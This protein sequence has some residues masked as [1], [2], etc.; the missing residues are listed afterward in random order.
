[1]EPNTDHHDGLRRKIKLEGLS[2]IYEIVPVG[3]EDLGSKWIQEGGADTIITVR[4]ILRFEQWS[5]SGVEIIQ[6]PEI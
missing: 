4:V 2:D 3:A 6:P 1:M 5:N